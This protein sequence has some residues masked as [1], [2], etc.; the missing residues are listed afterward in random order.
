MQVRA[1]QHAKKKAL[2]QAYD[3]HVERQMYL[4]QKKSMKK[5]PPAK[6][7]SP[8]LSR[9]MAEAR[10]S[11]VIGG[12]TKRTHPTL[13]SDGVAYSGRSSTRASVNRSSTAAKQ[14]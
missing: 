10:K 1:E 11:T 8:K 5:Q 13:D 3:K 7:G 12:S 6:I 14:R 4:D 9:V 2:S